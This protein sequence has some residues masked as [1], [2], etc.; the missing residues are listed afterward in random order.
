[1]CV[2]WWLSVGF[3]FVRFG[4]GLVFGWIR[5]G[6]EKPPT[7]MKVEFRGL[8]EAWDLGAFSKVMP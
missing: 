4:L 3:V 8:V 5:C 2:P 7:A 6:V 1:M